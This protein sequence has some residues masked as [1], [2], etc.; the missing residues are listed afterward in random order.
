MH[1]TRH[2][3]SGVG[4]T[5]P[6]LDMISKYARFIDAVVWSRLTHWQ[7]DAFPNVEYFLNCPSR[8]I[9]I[10]YYRLSWFDMSVKHD[11]GSSRTKPHSLRSMA[12]VLPSS[13]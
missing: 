3:A 6:S 5:G 12:L 9:I 1:A 7:I 4:I 8:V 10:R 2:V 11:S 13:V